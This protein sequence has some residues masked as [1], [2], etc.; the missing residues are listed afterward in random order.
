MIKSNDA[1]FRVRIEALEKKVRALDTS[2]A[3]ICVKLYTRRRW[4]QFW[5]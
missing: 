5:K 3:E 2:V 1:Q 4:W